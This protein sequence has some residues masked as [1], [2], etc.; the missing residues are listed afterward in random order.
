MDFGLLSITAAKS[1]KKGFAPSVVTA[2]TTK[3]T[4]HMDTVLTFIILVQGTT[5]IYTRG[6][7]LD[8]RHRE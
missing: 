1:V 8:P 7:R 4:E 6:L 2:V 3:T 5:L